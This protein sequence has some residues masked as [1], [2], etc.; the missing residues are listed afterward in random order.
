MNV[1]GHNMRSSLV[2]MQESEYTGSAVR[3]R[4]RLETVYLQYN[5]YGR[6][7]KSLSLRSMSTSCRDL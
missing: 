3:A 7:P 4:D 1:W 2:K 5:D 6:Q